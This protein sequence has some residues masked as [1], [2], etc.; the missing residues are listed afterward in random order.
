MQKRK[1]PLA[2]AVFKLT[3]ANGDVVKED[4]RTGEDG[5]A[6]IEGLD[7]ADYIVTEVT[8]PRWLHYR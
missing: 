3:R 4:I 5:T 7:A 8:A 2:N 1:K 6:F